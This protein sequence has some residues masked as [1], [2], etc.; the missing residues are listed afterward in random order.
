MHFIFGETETIFGYKKL[1]INLTFACDTMLSDLK[2]SY[3]SR[4]KDVGETKADDVEAM[5]AP[6]L[7]SEYV[8]LVSALCSSNGCQGQTPEA[9]SQRASHPLYTTPFKPPGIKVHEYDL[10]DGSFG[11]WKAKLTDPKAMEIFK[12]MQILT[13]M[14]IDGGTLVDLDDPQWT[15]ERWTIFFL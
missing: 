5:L 2:I 13:P 1:R 15:L 3:Q 6:Y 11:I 4:F 10:K 14:F 12:N 8:E 7:P 9:R